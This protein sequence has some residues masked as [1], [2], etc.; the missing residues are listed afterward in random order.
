MLLASCLDA[1]F[2]RERLLA[3]LAKI[4]G[5]PD[6]NCETE[7]AKIFSIRARRLRFTTTTAEKKHRHLSDI[8]K[9]LGES[10]LSDAIR[11]TALAV[12]TVL[13][14]AEARVHGTSRDKIHFHEVGALD[15]ILDIVG[16]S[17]IWHEWPVRELRLSHLEFG[18]GQV[19]CEHGPMPVPVPAVLEMAA[20]WPSVIRPEV[21]GE[22]VT[23]TAMAILKTLAIIRPESAH[24][25]PGARVGYGAGWRE[26]N[27]PNIAR[28][29]VRDEPREPGWQKDEVVLLETN[30]DD[31]SGRFFDPL[32]T[33][34]LGPAGA[35]D[36]WL[37]NIQ[38]K[39]NRPAFVL[40]V[41]CPPA[42]EQVVLSEVFAQ[43]T[44]L[45]IRR[46]RLERW[47]LPREEINLRW[48]EHAIRVKRATWSDGAGKPARTKHIPEF[49]DCLR[50]AQKTGVPLFQVLAEVR[51]LA[52]SL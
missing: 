41:L 39:K 15:S 19:E 2:P 10:E 34:L 3:G 43:T 38:M 9:L 48:R 51:T 27:Y 25:A 17:I 50:A 42:R 45:G 6:W 20:G 35:L 23:P 49:E 32:L 37:T 4:R 29:E 5:L 13:A 8:Q 33:T 14:E 40:S 26:M 46:R 16:F 18:G 12:F 1:G 47:I 21:K 22:M 30:L 31:V 7:E 24:L 11:A 52:E 36:A 28:L 44:T